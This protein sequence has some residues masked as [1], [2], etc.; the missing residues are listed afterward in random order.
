VRFALY[1]DPTNAGGSVAEIVRL[2]FEVELDVDVEVVVL[3]PVL[4][5]AGTDMPEQALNKRSS[6]TRVTRAA[7]RK[8]M[9]R[10]AS[11]FRTKPDKG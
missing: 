10:L 7:H 2:E 11:C 3:A 5:V 4:L 1:V 9:V 6:N 8:T